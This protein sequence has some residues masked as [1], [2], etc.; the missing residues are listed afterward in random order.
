MLLLESLHTHCAID[1][2]WGG[3]S[4]IETLRESIVTRLR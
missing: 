4:V 2:N 1:Q 3:I